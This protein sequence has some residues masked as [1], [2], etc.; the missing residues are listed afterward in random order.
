[1]EACKAA[2]EIEW[3]EP[4]PY[5]AIPYSSEVSFAWFGGDDQRT[6]G[7][8][9]LTRIVDAR[10]G[11]FLRHPLTEDSFLRGE[12]A[13]AIGI[14]S[15]PENWGTWLC[16]GGGEIVLG[17][18][19]DDSE[20][21][22]LFL[23]LRASGPLAESRIRLLANGEPV[24]EGAIGPQGRNIITHLR[25][26]GAGTASWLLRLR[27][28]VELS[29][30]TRAQIATLDRR[31]PTIGFERL[32]VVPENDLKTRVDILYTLLP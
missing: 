5:A 28:E 6:S 8:E 7:D 16:Q 14:W 31:V 13:R 25:R 10:R 27:V 26:R 15:E 18:A 4:Y 22:H 24:W 2:A 12:E 17:L 23:R 11:Y 19:P 29:P 1:M 9:L 3:R 30:E 21:Y 32:V 20:L